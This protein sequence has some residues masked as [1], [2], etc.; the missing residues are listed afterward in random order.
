MLSTFHD[1]NYFPVVLCVTMVGFLFG[2]VWYS[3]LFGRIW[4]VE[5]KLPPCPP[6]EKPSMVP[7]LIK[8]F[9]CTFVS[10]V[11]LGWIIA[12]AGTSGMRHGAALGAGLGLL[13]VG[14]RLA[15]MAVWERKSAKLMAIN[16]GHEVLLLALQ[17]ALLCRWL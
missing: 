4:Q 10:T 13:L 8:G 12:L 6:G 2:A 7:G 9:I 1:L 15:N 3:L 16:I 11:A 14:G 17:G 5:M